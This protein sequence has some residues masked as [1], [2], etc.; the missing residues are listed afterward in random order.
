MTKPIHECPINDWSC[1]YFSI[2]GKCLLENP[3]QECDDYYYYAGETSEEE[4]EQ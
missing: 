2:T 3:I 1:P 4:N